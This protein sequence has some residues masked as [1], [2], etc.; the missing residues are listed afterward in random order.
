MNVYVRSL[1]Y[2][3]QFILYLYISSLYAFKGVY[4][5]LMY[6]VK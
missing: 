5:I 3:F 2:S 6:P 4:V 1:F